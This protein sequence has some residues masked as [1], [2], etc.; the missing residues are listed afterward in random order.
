GL[1]IKQDFDTFNANVKNRS[2]EIEDAFDNCSNI[3]IVVAHVGS[4]IS[5]NAQEA[6]EKFIEEQQEDDERVASKIID[7][8]ASRTATDLSAAKAYEKINTDLWLHKLASVK[9]PRV[10]YF[11][12]I[13][14]TDL[15][16]LHEQY[17]R[18]LYAR[19]IRNFLGKTTEVNVAIQQ[20]LRDAPDQFV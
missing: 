6:L 5:A 1:L 10:T 9:D 11:G 17:G 3:Q 13:N 2:I 12:L 14:I 19:N 4:G 16:A 7:Y 8:D 18:A 20:T 15:V